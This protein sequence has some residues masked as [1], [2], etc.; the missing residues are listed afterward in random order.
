[1]KERKIKGKVYGDV[2]RQTS[3]WQI[4][5]RTDD[6]KEQ[7]AHLGIKFFWSSVWDT[8]E[9]WVSHMITYKN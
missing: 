2:Q 1:M 4:R 5:Q 3:K 8:R 6:L 9:Y 7:R